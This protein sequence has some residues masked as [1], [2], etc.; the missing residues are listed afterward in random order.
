MDRPFL[1][2]Q[3]TAGLIFILLLQ[4]SADAVSDSHPDFEKSVKPIL[5]ENCVR[6]HGG[7]HQ[8]AG[9]SFLSR[10][11]A[12]AKLESGRSAIV[13]GDLQN[14]EMIRRITSNDPDEQMPPDSQLGSQETSILQS[15]I[16]SGAHWP[17]HW[18]FSPLRINEM[19][20]VR[21]SE[22]PVDVFIRNRLDGIGW[23]MAPSAD[24]RTLIR[25]LSLDLTGLLPE[26]GAIEEFV[27]D[28][29]PDAWEMLV[30]QTLNSP[31]F[32]ERWGRYWLDQARYA[33]SDGY[34]KDK[35]RPNA[36][37]YR[38]WVIQSI[39]A[40]MPLSQFTRWQLAGDILFARSQSDEKNP[41]MLVASAFHRQTLFNTE[42]GVDPEED[43][44]KRVIDRLSTT[45]SIWLGLTIGC[46]QCHSHP[47]DPID[48]NEFYKLYAFFNNDKEVEAEVPVRYGQLSGGTMKTSVMGSMPVDN[49][50]A[51]YVFHR[52]D[53]LQPLIESGEV[54]P[55]APDVLI[56]VAGPVDGDD[57]LDLAD[58][59]ISSS[60][61]VPKRVL[62]NQI[63]EKL[64]GRG[65]VSTPDDWGA[66]GDTPSHPL[67]LDW[68]AFE[69]ERSGW[70]RKHIIKT[71]LLSETYRQ[72]AK[73]RPDYEDTD[74]ENSLFFRQ[75]RRRLEAESIRDI[76]LQ[77]AGLL[78]V[79]I[80]GPSV[81]PPLASDVAAQSYANNFRWKTSEGGNKFRRGI[82]TF[83][84]RTAPHPNLIVFDCS[85]SNASQPVRMV[86]NTPLQALTTLQNEVF[87][88]AARGFGERLWHHASQSG[89]QDS[90]YYQS[91]TWEYAFQLALARPPEGLN[92]LQPLL[93]LFSEALKFYSAHPEA[94]QE[95]VGGIAGS[96][97]LP[98]LA[99]L[100]AWVVS[101]RAI[102]NLDEFINRN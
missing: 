67:L 56:R 47:Y 26:P 20:S 50:R 73:H 66:R 101:A 102:L 75:N 6:C 31:H 93:G 83:F 72:S 15:W 100:A 63:W 88:E 60:N 89:S 94:A 74:P 71:I 33:D 58:W 18:S 46:A 30:D 13:P 12:T 97:E 77:A 17:Q 51:T 68:L 84:K 81:F 2:F 28:N 92:E 25:R 14:S 64:M 4:G 82:Y 61:P 65:L 87:L 34:E 29:S 62:V 7:V 44:T 42:G 9:L 49:R 40:D 45:A 19:V 96:V 48:H 5:M 22:N 98:K 41:E 36:W 70:S 53:F 79:T 24:R 55:G 78:D 52:G 76:F 32:G 16:A 8:K 54:L 38:D 37:R 43:R 1:R 57:R 10:S 85:D 86:S 95:F 27:N 91:G 59:L 80:G 35:P 21:Q 11:S 3:P 90:N 69:L 39:N 23:T 99:D